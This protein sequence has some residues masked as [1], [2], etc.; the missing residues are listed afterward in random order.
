[1][2]AEIDAKIAGRFQPDAL[3]IP[4][5]SRPLRLDSTRRIEPGDARRHAERPLAREPAG[6][7]AAVIEPV[8]LGRVA[9]D[10]MI[11]GVIDELVIPPPA[12]EPARVGVLDPADL[13]P[14]CVH[15]LVL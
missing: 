13:A 9:V 10:R 2:R 15:D 3:V 14:G 1:M 6:H 4:E 8:R 7:P 5:A 11:N 12:L